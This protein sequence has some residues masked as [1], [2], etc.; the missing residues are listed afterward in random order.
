MKISRVTAILAH[1]ITIAAASVITTLAARDRR[2][3]GTRLG[4]ALPLGVLTSKALKRAFPRRKK[5]LFT[6]TPR[7]SFPSGHAAATTAYAL[8]LFDAVRG[9]KVG[10][11]AVALIAFVDACRYHDDEHRPSELAVGNLIGLVAAVAGGLIARRTA[12]AD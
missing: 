1:P 2:G 3:V 6:L 4:V 10:A 12:P 5:R 9:R 8:S 7:E 11:A